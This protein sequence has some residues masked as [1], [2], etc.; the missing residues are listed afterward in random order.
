MQIPLKKNP[1]QMGFKVYL[2]HTEFPWAFESGHHASL[3]KLLLQTQYNVFTSPS[4]GTWA[5]CHEDVENAE[6]YQFP[7][8]VS[9][10]K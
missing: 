6:T 7:S 10:S 4:W 2:K 8:Y 3:P 1:E 5:P 9:Y